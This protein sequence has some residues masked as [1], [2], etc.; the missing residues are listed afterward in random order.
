MLGLQLGLTLK[1]QREKWM[2]SDGII[3]GVCCQTDRGSWRM[4]C[5]LEAWFEDSDYAA[6]AKTAGEQLDEDDERAVTCLFCLDDEET[7]CSANRH[8]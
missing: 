3:H 8:R 1:L 2:D 4:V 7:Y 5:G 6:C